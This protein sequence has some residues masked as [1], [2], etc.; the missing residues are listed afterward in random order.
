MAKIPPARI[1]DA[2]LAGVS[3]DR[4]EIRVAQV[5]RH[6]L[7]RDFA[8]EAMERAPKRMEPEVPRGAGRSRRLP[9]SPGAGSFQD[10]VGRRAG[11][12]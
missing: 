5:P 4:E 6:P 3:H 9:I 2:T 8:G 7:V 10:T 1:A 12:G 11:G